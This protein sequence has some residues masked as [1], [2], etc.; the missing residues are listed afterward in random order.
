MD[1]WNIER[2]ILRR[3]SSFS[4]YARTKMTKNDHKIRPWLRASRNVLLLAIDRPSNLPLVI[5][6]S[7]LEKTW[8]CVFLL[9]QVFYYSSFIVLFWRF[10][11][12]DSSLVPT[13]VLLY[14]WQPLNVF[15]TNYFPCP[16]VL[17]YS[18]EIKCEKKNGIKRNSSPVRH[19]TFPLQ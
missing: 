16:Q 2:Y 12:I 18:S 5:I 8:K 13:Q 4:S 10:N 11:F 19:V 7:Q 6:T 1:K 15:V 14:F 9:N 3:I 17:T